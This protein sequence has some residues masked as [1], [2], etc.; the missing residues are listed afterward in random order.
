MLAT[1]LA[2]ALGAGLLIA[3][4]AGSTT[5]SAADR[6]GTTMAAPTPRA[7]TS[8]LADI[9]GGPKM[10]LERH[11]K[12]SPTIVLVEGPRAQPR[13]FFSPIR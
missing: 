2:L 5:N 13:S 6:A 4:C 10:H 8:G 1:V 3:G 9:G 7:D 11:G 12:G